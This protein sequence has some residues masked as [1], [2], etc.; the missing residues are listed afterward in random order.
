MTPYYLLLG[1]PYI[2][3]IRSALNLVEIGVSGTVSKIS[4]DL[5]LFSSLCWSIYRL[6]LLEILFS[7]S[8]IAF[9]CGKI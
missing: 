4:S 8:S 2:R 1:K 5:L 9:S 7:M 3:S 6:S